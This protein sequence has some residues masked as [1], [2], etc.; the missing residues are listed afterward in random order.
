MNKYGPG[1]RM[2]SRLIKL[3][4]VETGYEPRLS[5]KLLVV[6]LNLITIIAIGYIVY[7]LIWR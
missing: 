4:E 7:S 3:P 5:A 6:M 2:N 1:E